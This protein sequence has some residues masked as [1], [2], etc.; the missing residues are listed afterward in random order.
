MPLQFL[1]FKS[2]DGTGL[3]WFIN[4]LGIVVLVLLTMISSV[5]QFLRVAKYKD[6]LE[7]YAVSTK[8]LI[9]LGQTI[10]QAE[11]K[12]IPVVRENQY[13]VTTTLLEDGTTVEAHG[14][15]HW[16]APLVIF[17]RDI[18]LSALAR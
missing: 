4:L 3:I 7:Q 11:Q 1:R 13:S 9:N 15:I 2:E 18:C 16:E 17:N 14:C 5:D 10:A 6:F 12:L 8:S